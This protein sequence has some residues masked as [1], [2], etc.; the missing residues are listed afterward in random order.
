MSWVVTQ[1]SLQSDLEMFKNEKYSAFFD[2]IPG[3][4]GKMFTRALAKISGN[5]SKNLKFVYK[6]KSAA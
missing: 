5:F 4:D 6:M 3:V 2:N 1:I